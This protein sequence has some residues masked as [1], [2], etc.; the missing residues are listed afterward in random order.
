LPRRTIRKPTNWSPKEWDHIEEAAHACGVP[1]LRYVREA[2]LRCPVPDGIV[3]APRPTEANNRAGEAANQLGRVLNNLRQLVR[4]AELDGDRGGAA[5][6]VEAASQ[7]EDAV[8]RL[9]SALRRDTADALARLVDAGIGL[10][11]LAHRAN[12]T[13]ELP[14][15]GDLFVALMEVEAAVQALVP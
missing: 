8:L 9:P 5:V 4:V 11:A 2:A 13:E 14:S 6:L 15:Q 1:P 10:N 7:V 3:P 12:G